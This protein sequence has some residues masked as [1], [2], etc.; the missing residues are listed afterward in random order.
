MSSITGYST[1]MSVVS[2]AKTVGFFYNSYNYPLIIAT[3]AHQIYETSRIVS[4]TLQAYNPT[5]FKTFPWYVRALAATMVPFSVCLEIRRWS[6]EYQPAFWKKKTIHWICDHIG[7]FAYTTSIISSIALAAIGQPWM[8]AGIVITFSI[9]QMQNYSI[10]PLYFCDTLQ[11][12]HRF[13][14]IFFSKEKFSCVVSVVFLLTEIVSNRCFSS[15]SIQQK[16]VGNQKPRVNE[17]ITSK[18][19]KDIKNNPLHIHFRLTIE[20]NIGEIL[21]I[22]DEITWHPAQHK[23]LLS[24]DPFWIKRAN[25]ENSNS[26]EYILSFRKDIENLIDTLQTCSDSNQRALMELCLKTIIRCLRDYPI[27]HLENKKIL[28]DLAIQLRSNPLARMDHLCKAAEKCYEKIKTLSLEQ[29]VFQLLYKRRKEIFNRLFERIFAKESTFYIIAY[30]SIKDGIK[31]FIQDAFDSHMGINFSLTDQ[32]P[33]LFKISVHRVCLEEEIPV[34]Q[35]FCDQDSNE[36]YTPQAI[37]DLLKKEMGDY[38]WIA[39]NQWGCKQGINM[40]LENKTSQMQLAKKHLQALQEINHEHYSAFDYLKN[41]KNTEQLQ[42]YYRCMKEDCKSSF[43]VLKVRIPVEGDSEE[44]AKKVCSD[45]EQAV[46]A[47][48]EMEPYLISMLLQIGVFQLKH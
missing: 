15:Q 4:K 33:D 40:D 47:Y 34:E 11:I 35:Y 28:L 30:Q 44:F 6:S 38:L 32:A 36:F 26:Q 16:P 13:A 17:L 45:I 27:E 10:L 19:I 18:T 1:G 42:Y 14:S 46:R 12:V 43:E 8:L 21:S 7:P 41:I 9:D 3:Q 24:Q 48:S 2:S 23:E 31:S 5:T 20:E 22:F 37:I 25:I 29:Q 39:I